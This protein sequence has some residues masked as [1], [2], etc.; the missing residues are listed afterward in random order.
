MPLRGE[1]TT[2]TEVYNA[3]ISSIA[4]VYRDVMTT[5]FID[6][7]AHRDEYKLFNNPHRVVDGP[8]YAF[9]V[10]GKGPAVGGIGFNQTSNMSTNV[11]IANNVIENVVCFTNEVPASVIDGAVQNDA[12]GG[13]V[14]L[15]NTF[16]NEFIA[17]DNERHYIGNV[18]TDAQIMVAKAIRDG[19]IEGNNI[20]QTGANTIGTG[21]IDWAM[22][23]LSVLD[24][25]FR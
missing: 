11:N 20:L 3:L 25:H 6:E 8:C 23:P 17:M 9:L 10:H 22:N 4:N 2:A 12:R 24:P 14:Q 7:Y 15:I 13:I 18:V 16:T 5:G 21:M 19:V 1:E